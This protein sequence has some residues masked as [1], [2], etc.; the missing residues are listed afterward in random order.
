MKP[1]DTIVVFGPSRN[2]HL[3]EPVWLPL[4]PVVATDPPTYVPYVPQLGNK[5]VTA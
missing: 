2:L 4:L 1:M 3:N 5:D